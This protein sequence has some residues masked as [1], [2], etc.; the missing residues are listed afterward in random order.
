MP[1]RKRG[2]DQD[3][4]R[5]KFSMYGVLKYLLPT[6]TT[7]QCG[8]PKPVSSSLSAQPY[9]MQ[10][11]PYNIVCTSISHCL[12]VP[13]APSA[14]VSVGAPLGQCFDDAIKRISWAFQKHSHSRAVVT[15]NSRARRSP[16]PPAPELTDRGPSQ[17][18]IVK[19]TIRRRV[20]TRLAG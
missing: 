7:P 1:L 2:A 3:D 15:S 9:C 17:S 19:P 12:P 8:A 16:F 11:A 6:G 4:A 18:D 5:K 10:C 14:G 20:D 13:P